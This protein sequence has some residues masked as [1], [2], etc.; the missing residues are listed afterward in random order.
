MAIEYRWAE[1]NPDRL[2][3]LVADLVRVKVNVVV[4]SGTAAIRA[5][6][7]VTSTVP[8]V[9]VYLADPVTAGFV[10]SL[11][12]PGGNLTGVAS[13]F[14]ALITKQLELLKEVVPT[15]SRVAVLHRPEIAPT[16]LSAAE[17]AARGLGLTARPFKV[18]EVAEF[19]PAFRTARRE[20]A[21]PS[22]CCPPRFSVC[23]VG[24]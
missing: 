20:G 22:T 9:F 5:A 24:C 21:G 17:M 18:A 12:R 14:E 1:G 7:S 2:P 15:I 16:V 6:R 8:I 19:E 10:P 4:V 13:E 11:A 3:A 23:S